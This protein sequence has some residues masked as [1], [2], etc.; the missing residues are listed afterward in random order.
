VDLLEFVFQQLQKKVGIVTAV[1][2][3]RM[4]GGA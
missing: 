4:K 3:V 1:V 2:E